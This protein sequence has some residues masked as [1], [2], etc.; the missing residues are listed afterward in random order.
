[1]RKNIVYYDYILMY[2]LMSESGIG[3]VE[4][5]G[6]FLILIWYWYINY[7]VGRVMVLI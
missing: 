2:F 3:L 7:V 4:D 6:F 1:M 5:N